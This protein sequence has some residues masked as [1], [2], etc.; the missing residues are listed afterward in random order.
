MNSVDPRVSGIRFFHDYIIVIQK[1][2]GSWY[3]RAYKG[4]HFIQR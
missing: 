2:V 1:A 4:I 3:D